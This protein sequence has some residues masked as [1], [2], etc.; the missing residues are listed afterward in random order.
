MSAFPARIDESD[1]DQSK[2]FGNRLQGSPSDYRYGNVS[3]ATGVREHLLAAI[4]LTQAAGKRLACLRSDSAGHT[5]EVI[6][7]CQEHG[8]TF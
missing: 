1:A 2:R 6:N 8:I 5:A 4:K 7:C 3:P